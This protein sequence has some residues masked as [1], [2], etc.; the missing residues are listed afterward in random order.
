LVKALRGSEER[1]EPVCLL[2]VSFAYAHF[3]DYC[4]AQQ[5]RFRLPVGSRLMD[6]GGYK[7]RMRE[8]PRE[9]LY[10]RLG[11]TLGIPASLIVNEYGMTE[12]CSQFYDNVLAD[13]YRDIQRSRRK[14]NPRWV[15]T[16]I[17]NP[18]TLEDLPDGVPGILQHYD[19][20]NAGSVMALQT[21]DLGFR[22]EDGFE[23]IGRAKLSEAR[24]CSLSMEEFLSI[25]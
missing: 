12:M 24:G 17:L 6:T 8:I 15:R 2:G 18:E 1:S 13:R 22:I 5:L 21:E 9:E 11:K 7:G 4:D 14:V 19:L 3:M 23:I 16:R 20:A 25:Q 10:Y